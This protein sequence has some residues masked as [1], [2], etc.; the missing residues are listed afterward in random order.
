MRVQCLY[1]VQRQIESSVCTEYSDK[2]ESIVST[3]YSN[4]C[5]SS[6]CTDYSD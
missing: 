2:C 1:K 6:V 4:K 5:D 3:E